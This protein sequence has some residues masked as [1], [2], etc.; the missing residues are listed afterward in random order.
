MSFA[1]M[2]KILLGEINPPA[3]QGWVSL[4]ELA[5]KAKELDGNK[6]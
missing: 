5:D 6:K 4:Q 3:G 2:L 1:T